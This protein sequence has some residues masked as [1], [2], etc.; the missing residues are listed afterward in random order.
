[1]SNGQIHTNGASGNGAEERQV[2]NVIVIGS[3][4]RLYRWTL[5]RAWK[6]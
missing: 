1:M 5:Y 4:S 3:G 6:I 2:E